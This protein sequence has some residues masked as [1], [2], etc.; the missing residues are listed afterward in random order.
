MTRLSKAEVKE[1]QE[2]MTGVLEDHIKPENMYAIKFIK[3]FLSICAWMD[4]LYDGD[5]V[6]TQKDAKALFEACLFQF[7]GNPFYIE[8]AYWL[9]PTIKMIMT[10]WETSTGIEERAKRQLEMTGDI[11]TVKSLLQH[12]FETRNTFF[13][14]APVCVEILYGKNARMDFAVDWYAITRN[15]ETLED[16][17][18]KVTA[19]ERPKKPN[20]FGEP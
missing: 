4:D 10:D 17:M 18:A 13:N 11:A 9:T 12:S 2:L 15:Y 3:T 16:Y 5:T 6:F 20:Y 1:R 8:N 14:I 19:A 7:P